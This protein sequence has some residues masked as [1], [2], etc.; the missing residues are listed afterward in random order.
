MIRSRV[1][2]AALPLSDLLVVRASAL[3]GRKRFDWSSDPGASLLNEIVLVTSQLQTSQ[4]VHDDLLGRVDEVEAALASEIENLA[5]LPSSST[6]RDQLA[7][8]ILRLGEE[9]RRLAKERYEK[10]AELCDRLLGLLNQHAQ[11]Q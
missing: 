8:H 6:R 2:G 10:L 7:D 5:H 4:H 3:V 9:R 1:S 11:L